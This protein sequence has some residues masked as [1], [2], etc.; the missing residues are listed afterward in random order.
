MRRQK[1]KKEEKEKTVDEYLPSRI[2]RPVRSQIYQLCVS[3]MCPLS[4]SLSLVDRNMQLELVLKAFSAHVAACGG[5]P[6]YAFSHVAL[7]TIFC[8]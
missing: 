8:V 4:R 2:L 1:K 6:T 3:L 7:Y 5:H